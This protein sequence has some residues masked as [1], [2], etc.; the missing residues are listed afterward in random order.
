MTTAIAIGAFLAILAV[1]YFLW[2]AALRLG[3]K[4]AKAKNVAWWR[5]AAAT[6]VIFGLQLSID[7]APRAFSFPAPAV[8]LLAAQ[9]AVGVVVSCLVI[10]RLF[11]LSLGRAFQAWLP[12]LLAG[13]ASAAIVTLVFRPFLVE[14]FKLPTN[15][16]APTLLGEHRL[17]VC[18]VCGRPAFGAPLEDS[19]GE[20]LLICEAFHVSEVEEGN[21]QARGDRIL[22]L[23]TLAPRRWDLI[24]F[25]YP[26][27]P[28]IMF[29]KRLVGLPGETV[30]IDEGAVWIDGERLTPP[31]EL[32]GIEYLSE[33]PGGGRLSGSPSSPARLGSDEYFVLG[34][35][36]ARSKDSRLWRRSSPGHNAYAVPEDHLVGVVTHIYWP[37]PRWRVVR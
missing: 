21:A 37:P 35:F 4:W 5:I 26:E 13:I 8:A 32:A 29:V 3:L 17:G 33:M 9:L 16:M 25:R 19:Y 22:V 23:K 1:S 24:V 10:A 12:T 2:L 30:T 36:S 28:S 34:D 27:D 7:Q 15:A 6:L 31:E 11:N 14:A 20:P 18:P